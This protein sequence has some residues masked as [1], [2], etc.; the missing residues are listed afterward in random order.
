M[1]ILQFKLLIIYMLIGFKTQI[2]YA[3]H[4]TQLEQ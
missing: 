2:I 4:Q 1:E 3:L